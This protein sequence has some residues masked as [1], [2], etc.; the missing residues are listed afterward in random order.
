VGEQ[1]AGAGTRDHSAFLD[2]DEKL[3]PSPKRDLIV[4]HERS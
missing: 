3:K 2:L 1:A 4:P